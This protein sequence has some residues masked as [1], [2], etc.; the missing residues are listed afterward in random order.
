MV[1]AEIVDGADQIH[2]RVQRNGAPS[3]GSA[4]AGERS[5]ALTESGIEPF[6]I[7]GVKHATTTLRAAPELLGLGGCAGENAALNTDHAPLRVVLD[8]LRDME[9]FPALQVWPTGLARR[10]WIP[11]G[12][13]DRTGVRPKPIRAEQH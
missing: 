1:G 3:Q 7:R 9:G 5:Q 10:Q 2:P 11:K 12:F 8:D 4:P 13:P 6:D